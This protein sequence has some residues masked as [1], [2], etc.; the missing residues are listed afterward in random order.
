MAGVA[1]IALWLGLE[2]VQ[3]IANAAFGRP[4]VS[5]LSVQADVRAVGKALFAATERVGALHWAWPLLALV[6]ASLG[7][8]AVLRARV[9]AVEVVQ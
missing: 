4:E 1:L 7:C 6:L 8:L 5:L 2:V 9:R 3:L